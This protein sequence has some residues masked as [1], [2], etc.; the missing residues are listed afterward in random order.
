MQRLIAVIERDIRKFIRNP[1]I[2][3]M[4]VVLP[5][6]YLIILGNS[7]Q[8]KL[9]NVPVAVV[10]QDQGP[11]GLRVIENLRGVQAGP[12]TLTLTNMLDQVEAVNLVKKGT[13]KAAVVIPPDFTRKAVTNT[14]PEV[15]L[16]IDDT[17]QISTNTVLATVDAAISPV[18]D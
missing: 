9:K 14:G 17:D 7:F 12:E 15:G 6:A 10:N 18:R 2:M 3:V 1:I 13:F 16:F 11:F 4:S 5:I 8:G